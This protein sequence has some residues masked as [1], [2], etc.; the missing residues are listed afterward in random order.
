MVARSRGL[1]TTGPCYDEGVVHEIRAV[2][3]ET[4]ERYWACRHCGARGEVA[5]R[6]IGDSGWQTESLILDVESED[7]TTRAEED[8]MVDAERV[9][10]L[11]RCPTCKRRDPRYV[12]WARLRVGA[13]LAI[14]GGALLVGGLH[15]A[16]VAGACGL[17]GAWQAFRER[18]R[19]VR[20]DAATI[21]HLQPGERPEPSPAPPRPVQPPPPV[22]PP[23]RAITAPPVP[24]VTPR[25]PGEEPAFLKKD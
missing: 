7:A 19:F 6:A 16:I 4:A 15:A 3:S 2:H 1:A 12:R 10:H 9:L 22:L 20:A 25:G 17:I 21:L 5:F 11:I 18:S 24:A 23:A 14:G 8:L 13:W